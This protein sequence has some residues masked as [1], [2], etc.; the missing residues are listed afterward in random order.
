MKL[1]VSTT[2]VSQGDVT[3]VLLVKIFAQEKL[4]GIVPAGIADDGHHIAYSKGILFKTKRIQHRCG[5]RFNFHS[6]GRSV[7]LPDLENHINMRVAESVLRDR[8]AQPDFF[9]CVVRGGA[10]MRQS[11][12]GKR[13]QYEAGQ[14]DFGDIRHMRF[15]LDQYNLFLYPL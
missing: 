2:N 1:V 15:L 11:G 13:H 6:V 7:R 12:S 4:I 5:A 8:A 10:V 3:A 14:N 9:L